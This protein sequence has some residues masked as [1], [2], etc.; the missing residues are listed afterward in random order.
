[1]TTQ[2][3]GNSLTFVTFVQSHSDPNFQT[4]CSKPNSIWS[5]SMGCWYE[6]VFT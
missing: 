2:G 1:M 4:S 3:Q 6:N 5:G